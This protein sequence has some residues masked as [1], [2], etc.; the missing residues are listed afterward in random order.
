MF[1]S[2]INEKDWLIFFVFDRH[3]PQYETTNEYFYYLMGEVAQ[4]TLGDTIVAFVDVVDEGE[5]L[6]E[7]FDIESTPS[8]VWVKD[9]LV[10]HLPKKNHFKP[11]DFTDFMA[12]NNV[13]EL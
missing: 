6:K 13:K 3:S 9:Q 12:S 4:L 2:Y 7:T 10:T 5:S 1:D 11:T 8:V